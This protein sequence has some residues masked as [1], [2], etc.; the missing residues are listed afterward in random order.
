L[1]LTQLP[2]DTEDETPT[3]R[4]RI[5]PGLVDPPEADDVTRFLEQTPAWI[6]LEVARA[7]LAIAAIPSFVGKALLAKAGGSSSG[8]AAPPP[9]PPPWARRELARADAA[10]E[11][12]RAKVSA[13]LKSAV[14]TAVPA[15]QAP[16]SP[17]HRVAAQSTSTSAA[18]IGSR[19]SAPS[20]RWKGIRIVGAILVLLAVLVSIAIG[21][22]K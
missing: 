12:V 9:L 7:D 6:A 2:L 16:P 17:V 5:V 21:T 8:R 4:I 13:A 10:I 18:L 20:N 1:S 14:V 22:T 3:G 19:Q 15:P 11:V